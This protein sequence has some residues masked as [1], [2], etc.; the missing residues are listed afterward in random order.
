M[1]YAPWQRHWSGL[2]AWSTIALRS[3]SWVNPLR[4]HPASQ[5]RVS[6][7]EEALDGGR[8]QVLRGRSQNLLQNRQGDSSVVNCH[9]GR[10]RWV[11]TLNEYRLSALI[12]CDLRERCPC[13]AAVRTSESSMIASKPE[14]LSRNAAGAVASAT[15]LSV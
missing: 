3:G 15:E 4:W 14:C 6:G 9:V 13:Q 11:P 2:A 1:V 10:R 7:R 8:M 12:L 5:I